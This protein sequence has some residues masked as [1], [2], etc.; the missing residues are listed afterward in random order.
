MKENQRIYDCNIQ[1]ALLCMV[2]RILGHWVEP[3]LI[4]SVKVITGCRPKLFGTQKTLVY[5]TE[6]HL[7][8][9]RN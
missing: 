5:I 3:H 1:L 9:R 6:E 4:Y 7:R 8:I 2:F